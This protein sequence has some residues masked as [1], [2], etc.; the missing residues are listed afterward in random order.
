M[1]QKFRS[2]K[3]DSTFIKL[4]EYILDHPTI[5]YLHILTNFI[6]ETT[7]IEKAIINFSS[8]MEAIQIITKKNNH[9]ISSLKFELTEPTRLT[10]KSYYIEVHRSPLDVKKSYRY[11]ELFIDEYRQIEISKLEQLKEKFIFTIL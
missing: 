1:E 7:G 3:F 2:K 8:P 9:E 5:D 10:P 11:F 6:Y 4:F